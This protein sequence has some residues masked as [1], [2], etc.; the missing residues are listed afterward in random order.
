MADQEKILTPNEPFYKNIPGSAVRE[1]SESS[2][3]YGVLPEQLTLKTVDFV[4]LR[5]YYVGEGEGSKKGKQV[6]ICIDQKLLKFYLDPVT[7]KLKYSSQIVIKSAKEGYS[8]VRQYGENLYLVLNPSFNSNKNVQVVKYTLY[9]G[10][11]LRNPSKKAN[12]SQTR[13]NS[14]S[15]CGT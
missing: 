9:K 8:D 11:I 15:W 7:G 4:Q 3:Y 13:R 6:Y 2:A 10:L 14:M 12:I 1:M 5:G